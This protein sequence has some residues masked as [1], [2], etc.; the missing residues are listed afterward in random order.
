[1]WRT[2]KYADLTLQGV[3]GDGTFSGYASVFGEVDLGRDEIAPGAFVS[4]D[5]TNKPKGF[6]DYTK[7]ADSGWSWGSI[8]YIATG[9][10]GGFKPSGPADTLIDVVYAL[11]A[12]HR[13]NGT[14]VMNRKTQ[15]S[16]RKFKD[17]E[18]N[19]LWRPPANAGNPAS[20]MG[21][22]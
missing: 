21:F 8:G 16:I 2:K 19:Y 12:G 15:G 14:F 1:V 22:A 9:A 11:K 17:A 20:L 5:G 13:Q 6:L 10:A 4:G 3:S 7:V 18:G